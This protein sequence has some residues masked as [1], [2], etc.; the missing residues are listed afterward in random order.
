MAVAEPGILERTAR[1]AGWVVAWRMATRVL[2]LVSTLVLARLLVPEDF[3]LVALATSFAFALD[4]CFLVGV[5]DQIIRARDAN[6]ALYDTAFTMSLIRGVAVGVLVALFAPV[7]AAFFGDERLTSILLALALALA[8][9]GLTNIGTVD[10][11]RYLN[12]HLE[13]RLMLLPRVASVLAAIATAM[14][15]RSYWALVVGII[16]H[17]GGVIAM[18]YAMHPYRPRLSLSAWR[19][20]VGVSFWAW[21]IGLAVMVRDR[22]DAV[23][24][25]RMSGPA[26]FGTF[27]AGSELATVTTSEMAVAASRAVMPGLADLRRN[28]TPEAEREALLRI[29]RLMLLFT[30]PFG[31]GASLIAGPAVVAMLGP[32][33]V[34][35]IPVV[36]IIALAGTLSPLDTVGVGWLRAQAALRTLLIVVIGSACL[37][38][39]LLL[40]LTGPF[41]LWGAAIA[42]AVSMAAEPVVTFIIVARRLDIAL[43]SVCQAAYRP[44]IAAAC[45]ATVLAVLGLG[46]AA[47]PADAAAA[48][49]MLALAIPCGVVTYCSVLLALWFAAGMAAGAEADALGALRRLMDALR[50]RRMPRPGMAR[51]D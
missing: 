40:V 33:W 24:I 51:P 23:V 31:V 13:F 35:A 27:A 12:F 25:G 46:W 2:G 1:G 29:V 21:A 44:L 17:R 45:M 10:F 5:E 22:S 38:F 19:D 49:R 32:R 28:N 48:L 41:G 20:L 18:S 26:Q 14:L 3:G 36:A 8:A 37:R 16:V 7:A 39:G 50:R 6:R 47:P 43:A 42:V 34:E 4:A 11:R 15:F 9:S 30:L